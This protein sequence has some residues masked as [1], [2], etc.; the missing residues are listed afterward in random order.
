MVTDLVQ[1]P[2]ELPD[3]GSAQSVCAPV[4]SP[5]RT[6][7]WQRWWWRRRAATAARTRAEAQDRAAC[8]AAVASAPTRTAQVLDDGWV[9]GAWFHVRLRS[10]E[11]RAIGPLDLPLPSG[12]PVTGACLIGAV[13][14]A[15]DDSGL[16]PQLTHSTV[17]VLWDA[18][19]D[20]LGTTARRASGRAWPPAE[21]TLRVRELTRW[22]DAPGRTRE[23]VAAL[24]AG[25]H[26]LA[27]RE[28]V[29]R[30]ADG[31]RR[32]CPGSPTLTP[33]PCCAAARSRRPCVTSP[34]RRGSAGSAGR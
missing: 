13:V 32:R 30:P 4:P 19:Q 7:G 14:R 15:T 9:Q 10:G 23:Q 1:R 8:R 26:R 21:R 24:V 31:S 12:T 16:G 17:D 22:N 2:P 28:D 20:S 6:S 29:P 33:C 34:C 18:L 25:A 5:A 11:R 27:L 3:A